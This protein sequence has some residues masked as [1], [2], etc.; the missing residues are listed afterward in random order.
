[1]MCVTNYIE[2]IFQS[3]LGDLDAQL[4]LIERL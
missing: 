1:M 2:D 4:L 3:R